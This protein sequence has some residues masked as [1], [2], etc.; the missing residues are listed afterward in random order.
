M[1]W[2][3]IGAVGETL[4][5]IAVLLSLLYLGM[6]IKQNTRSLKSAAYQAAIASMSDMARATGTDLQTARVVRIFLQEDM[7]DLSE[8]E[9]MM[10][11]S[12]LTGLF[13]N[14]EN[15]YY[16][17][18]TGAM[19]DHLWVGMRNSMVG[20][21]HMPNVRSWWDQRKS[22]Y[23]PQFVAFLEAQPKVDSIPTMQEV[24]T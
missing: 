4:G 17:H 15:F 20:Y 3:A 21:H 23:S 2:E 6:Q 12:Y 24:A 10:A 19:E 5:A 14:F 7:A 8:D 11:T 22:I 13:R 1:N 18:E 9:F 16:Q